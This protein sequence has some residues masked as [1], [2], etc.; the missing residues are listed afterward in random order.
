MKTILNI[1][2]I[3][4]HLP[5]GLKVQLS[6]K[7]IF[8]LDEEFPQ[9]HNEICEITNILKCNNEWQVEIS[10]VAGNDSFGLIDLDEI[11]PLLFPM[12]SLYTE[13]E[14]G[15]VPMKVIGEMF[16][17]DL[18]KYVDN[19]GDIFYGFELTDTSIPHKV[20]MEDRE[21]YFIYFDTQSRWF[22]MVN[23]FLEVDSDCDHIPFSLEVADYLDSLHCDWRY[24]LIDKGLALDKT[25]IK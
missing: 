14:D 19:D 9:P 13:M 20:P 10:D 1:K 25:K 4:P 12:S 21:I 2:H 24:G 5:Y 23:Q 22:Y 18:K 15:K 16:E 3:A 11:M 8:N 17:Y 6:Q 7:G